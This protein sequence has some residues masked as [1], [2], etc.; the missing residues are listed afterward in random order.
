MDPWGSL[1]PR[2]PNQNLK[3]VTN[4]WAGPGNKTEECGIEILFGICGHTQKFISFTYF[5]CNDMKVICRRTQL[6]VDNAT[7]I[8]CLHLGE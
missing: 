3:Q 8:I 7:Y 4:T 6:P 5:N 2:L 1:V